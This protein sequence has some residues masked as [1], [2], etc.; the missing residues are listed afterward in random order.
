MSINAEETVT[1]GPGVWIM[2]EDLPNY[3]Y[4]YKLLKGKVSIHSRDQKIN[5]LEVKEGGKPIILG[6]IA[7]LQKDRKHIASVRSETEI[8]VMRMDIDQTHGIL[9]NDIPQNLKGDVIT[10]VDTITVKN[11]IRSLQHKLEDLPNVNPELPSD[12]KPAVQ[13]LLSELISLYKDIVKTA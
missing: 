6:M 13:E 1:I 10:M 2:T 9:T 4:F 8:E 12:M 11:E 7:A 3:F 5:E